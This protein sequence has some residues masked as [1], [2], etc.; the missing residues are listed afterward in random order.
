MSGDQN[1]NRIIANAENKA[2]PQIQKA[3]ATSW[4]YLTQ[5]VGSF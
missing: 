5:T 2:C 4:L 1:H 3:A